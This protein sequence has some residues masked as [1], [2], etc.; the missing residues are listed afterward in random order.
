MN[1]PFNN[2]TNSYNDFKTLSDLRWH[3]TKCELVSGQAKT[4]Q[5]WRQMGIQLDTDEKGNF[6]KTIHCNRCNKNTIHRKLK[7]TEL[8]AETKVRAGLNSKL[9]E[10]I[11]KVYNFEEA[12]LL[13]QMLPREIEVDHKFPQVRWEKNEDI[14]SN[15]MNDKEIK[16][17]FMLLTRSN[18][19]LKSRNCER[20]VKTGKRGYF[21]GIYYWY[22]G[23]DNWDKQYDKDDENGC[24]GC[25][26]YD[27]YKW[28]EE[29]NKL[30][31][32]G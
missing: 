20:C 17:K 5:I 9:A 13:R 30:I 18:N 8:A 7:S 4:W 2:N 12:V 3:C 27:P 6:Y 21:P 26:W 1:N 28:R 14:H 31:K 19:L 32:A 11:K 15:D 29:L 10:K 24:I 25:F 22:I 16:S 23:I